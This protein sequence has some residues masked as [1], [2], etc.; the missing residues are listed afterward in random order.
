MEEKFGFGRNF[1][2]IIAVL[3]MLCDHIACVF[4]DAPQYLVL[5]QIMRAVGRISFILFCFVLVQG[6]LST[7]DL[8]KY[9]LRLFIFA[10]ISEIPF[11]LAFYGT[12]FYIGQQ[13]VLFTFLIGMFV[14]MGVKKYE[15][16]IWRECVFIILGCVAAWLL[17]SDYTYMGILIIVLFYLFRRDKKAQILGAVF[18]IILDG[19]MEMF[20]L[21]ALPFCYYYLPQKKEKSLPKYF[22]YIFYPAHLL[23]L[24]GLCNFYK[25]QL[26]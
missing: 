6:F 4:F 1:I 20:A 5:Y 15:T 19:G 16:S 7:R 14:L 11:D 3:S 17:Q 25:I 21:F 24:W 18:L 2:K 12:A 8:K 22:F 10:L 13:N 23:V 26:Y 9:I